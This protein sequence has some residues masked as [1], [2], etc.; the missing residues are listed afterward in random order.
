MPGLT[1]AQRFG[2]ALRMA[3]VDAVYGR[4][5]GDLAVIDV[6]DAVGDL[7]ALAHSRI[8]G[9]RAAVHAG[10]GVFRLPGTGGAPAPVTVAAPEA[11]A[12]AAFFGDVGVELEATFDPDHVATPSP[13]IPTP[14]PDGWEEPPPEAVDA[15]RAAGRITVLAGPGVIRAAAV[16]GLHDLAVAGGLGV[17][18]TWGA[19]GI[20]HWRSR[21]HLATIGLQA[22][23]FALGGLRDADLILATGLDQLESPDPRWQLAPS[24]VIDPTALAALAE[25]AP[26]RDGAPA[27][28][29]L[30]AALA[31]VTQRG[32]QVE[33]G[34][35]PPSRVTLQ[36]GECVAAGGLVAADAGV[37]GY[38]VAR[39]LGT[40]RLG[41]VVVPAH[42]RAGFAAACVAVARLHHPHRPALAVVDPA[43]A[44]ETEL[45]R[46]AAHQ[47]GV[48]VP[49]EV[50][51]A[52][53]ERL[54]AAAHRARLLELMRMEEPAPAAPPT[55]ATDPRQ[56]D[57]MVEAAGPVVAWT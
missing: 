11:I 13:V 43:T 52:D 32:W 26:R 51:A 35:L 41:G 48:H 6:P 56:L 27:M 15:M 49:I 7:F 28:P 29:P 55:L 31:A 38:W 5:F 40:T 21:H 19:K 12:P 17:L 42:A 33:R 8:H 44:A 9:V 53:G 16:P 39:T 18:N 36:Y 24:L 47:L 30:R 3:G 54:D 2:R 46:D 25:H 4:P 45:V 22:D 50:W 10:N 57:E 14:V 34:P 37:A 1:G 23:D 20:F